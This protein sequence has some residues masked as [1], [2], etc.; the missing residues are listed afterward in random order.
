VRSVRR[1]TLRQPSQD[2]DVRVQAFIRGVGSVTL[3]PRVDR[4]D[5]E[6]L[7]RQVRI[8]GPD[9]CR[10]WIRWCKLGQDIY[11]LGAVVVTGLLSWAVIA[12]GFDLI[13][14]VIPTLAF[15]PDLAWS[16]RRRRGW[17]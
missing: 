17:L 5:E 4:P 10:A 7:L 11:L 14:V 12:T 15:V 16:Y 8:W 1:W 9:Q 6:T 13:A 3:F 2:V